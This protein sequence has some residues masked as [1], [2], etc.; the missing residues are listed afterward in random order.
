MLW[1]ATLVRAA[2]RRPTAA[3][4]KRKALAEDE[5]ARDPAATNEVTEVLMVLGLANS[6]LKQLLACRSA[7]V[8]T[9]VHENHGTPWMRGGGAGGGGV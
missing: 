5:Q 6:L 9:H 3:E 7:V 4:G 2:E 8:P 1:E